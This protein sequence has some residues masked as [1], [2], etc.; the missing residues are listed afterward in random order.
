MFLLA[1]VVEPGGAAALG[2]RRDDELRA[3]VG[4]PA[5]L[6]LAQVGRREQGVLWGWGAGGG[7]QASELQ[8]ERRGNVCA[9][10]L[11]P[12]PPQLRLTQSLLKH[13]PRASSHLQPG[14]CK[15]SAGLQ[16]NGIKEESLSALSSGWAQRQP[17]HQQNGGASSMS[18]GLP[19][20]RSCTSLA[21]LRADE[22]SA[23]ARR[24]SSGA[25]AHHRRGGSPASA[26]WPVQAPAQRGPRPGRPPPHSGWLKRG[27][28]GT[29]HGLQR[30]LALDRRTQSMCGQVG[31]EAGA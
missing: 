21:H 20:A 29:S 4:G 5:A 14:R 7:E 19:L 10:Q 15:P 18:P 11:E 2:P 31:V 23:S 24:Q 12:G 27:M 30:L 1:C 22:K 6:L 8:G 3:R 17:P 28:G 26:L 9:V 25:T 13:T 16:R